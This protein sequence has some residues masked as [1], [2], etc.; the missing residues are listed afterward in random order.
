[1]GEAGTEVEATEAA[2]FM[3]GAHSTEAADFAEVA[4]FMGEATEAFAAGTE[5]ITV[6]ITAQDPI[7]VHT[8]VAGT[9]LTDTDQS[10]FPGIGRKHVTPGDAEWSGSPA[11]IDS[12]V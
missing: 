6:V 5:V 8:T 11:T 7:I 3:A 10:G 9:T 2:D 4:D 12:F 1:M